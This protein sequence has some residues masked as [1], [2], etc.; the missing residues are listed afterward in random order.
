MQVLIVGDV[1]GQL[2][3]LAAHLAAVRDGLGIEAAIQV[4][5]FGFDERAMRAAR[6]PYPVPVYVIDGNHEDHRWLHRALA[7]G[8]TEAWR[9][10]LRLFYQARPSVARIG[11]ST[12][13]FIG[14]ALHVDRP[15]RHNRAQGLPNYILRRQA[16]EASLLFD[17]ARPDLIVSHSCPSSIG[18]GLTG[19][20]AL[21][22]G[23][24]DH[25]VSAGFDPGPRDDC[26]EAEL[27]RIWR[28]LRHRPKAWVFGHHHQQHAVCIGQTR[29]VCVG[30]LESSESRPV[31]WDTATASLT[32][33]KPPPR[34]R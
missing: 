4:G 21:Q 5:D 16:D 19:P 18:I 6:A 2:E 7:S 32:A 10:D 29:F 17:E 15:Q 11:G 31:I 8:E 24:I 20:D 13:G 12:V 34:T 30:D 1:H 25:I 14:G 22:G 3:R 28:A 33:G 9:S 27:S 23:V 26:G